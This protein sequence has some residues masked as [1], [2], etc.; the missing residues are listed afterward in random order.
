MRS[1]NWDRLRECLKRLEKLDQSNK[2]SQDE[3]DSI[4][5]DAKEAV[6]NNT[7]FLESVM[8]FNPKD[9]ATQDSDSSNEEQ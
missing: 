2:L 6:G 8:N 3:F 5:K 1:P 9:T 4:L 7:K